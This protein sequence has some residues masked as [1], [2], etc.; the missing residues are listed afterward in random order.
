MVIIIKLGYLGTSP[1]KEYITFYRVGNC[2][3]KSEKHS[4]QIAMHLKFINMR[5]TK[6][7]AHMRIF[8]LI[9]GEHVLDLL[10]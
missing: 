6:T 9:D 1:I 8:S 4:V 3:G 7:T 5:M 10:T 2:F